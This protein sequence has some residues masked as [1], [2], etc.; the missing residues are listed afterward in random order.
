[1]KK[2]LEEKLKVSVKLKEPTIR[3]VRSL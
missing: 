2:D 3:I 1:M